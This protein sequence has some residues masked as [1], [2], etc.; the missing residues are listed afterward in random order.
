MRYDRTDVAF[1]EFPGE[2]SLL[3]NLT[4]CPF[5]CH[6]CHS[7]WLREDTGI[8]LTDEELMR[9]LGYHKGAVTCVG[10]MGGDADPAEVSR[11]A[12]EAKSYGFR[13]GWYS[14]ADEFSPKADISAFD[15]VKVGHYDE[16]CGG[17]ASPSTNQRF[18]V[19]RDGKPE[20][21]TEMFLRDK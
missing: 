16:E 4:G 11:L 19:I 15:Y 20:D 2:V 1:Q 7:P 5:S 14:G 17:L 3:I 6:G 10:F 12:C 13:T 21:R 9:L 8:L 18:Y